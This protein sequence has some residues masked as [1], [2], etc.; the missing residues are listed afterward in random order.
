MRWDLHLNVL[1]RP[2]YLAIQSEVFAVAF[3]SPDWPGVIGGPMIGTTVDPKGERVRIWLEPPDGKENGRKRIAG[4]SG[5]VSP[6]L[7]RL[8]TGKGKY[9]WY[10]VT[11]FTPICRE[12]TYGRF[13]DIDIADGVQVSD[14]DWRLLSECEWALLITPWLSGPVRVL[15]R[16]HVKKG[17]MRLFYATRALWGM[18]PNA[19]LMRR[20]HFRHDGI[21]VDKLGQPEKKTQPV[22]LQRIE[23]IR[24]GPW[25]KLRHRWHGTL[26]GIL[27]A[28]KVPLRCTEAL[29]GDEARSVIRVDS[30]VLDFLGVKSGDRI[31]VS[32][33]DREAS[34]RVLL[35]TP[36]QRIQMLR[37]FRGPTGAGGDDRR[38]TE[39]ADAPTAHD[40][41]PS[42][43][44]GDDR[45]FP[46]W[47]LQA[48][49]SPEIRRALGIP[50]NTVVTLRRNVSYAVTRNF[51]VLEIPVAALIIAAV[52]VPGATGSSRWW[53]IPVFVVVTVLLA[54][55][56]LR[57]KDRSASKKT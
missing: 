25:F 11:A 4:I 47:H 41:R 29:V 6:S 48:W 28:P 33:A 2:Q 34:A 32:W 37:Q 39:D 38:D 49:V 35:Q 20:R 45:K 53:W 26:E 8:F 56:P 15:R 27:G 51:I 50:A 21:W 17:K 5:G 46:P 16:D 30:T 10:T 43:Q 44:T 23:T 31:R 52:A 22:W 9:G 1:G 18:E 42:R 54:F 55:I 24:R 7:D 3:R 36:D 19:Q 40:R 12:W 13:D 57:L 14:D